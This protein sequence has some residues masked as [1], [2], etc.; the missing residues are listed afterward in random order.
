[1]AE[2]E[3]QE[4]TGRPRLRYSLI[5]ILPPLFTLSCFTSLSLSF[6]MCKMGMLILIP[7]L[8]GVMSLK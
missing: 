2:L 1:M 5:H 6:S 4:Y 3:S 7:P 8:P